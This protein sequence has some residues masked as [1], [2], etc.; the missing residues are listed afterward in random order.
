MDDLK[1]ALER[2]LLEVE[3]ELQRVDDDGHFSDDS[4]NDDNPLSAHRQG[5]LARQVQ[6]RSV[7]ASLEDNQNTDKDGAD[8]QV[9]LREELSVE[10]ERMVEERQ[11]GRRTAHRPAWQTES[12]VQPSADFGRP[13]AVRDKIV[14]R[15]VS[16][17]RIVEKDA[18]MGDRIMCANLEGHVMAPSRS[19]VPG[20]QEGGIYPP[21]A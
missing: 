15:R 7:L 12:S 9:E 6:L 21:L 1:R 13:V 19:S 18:E 16:V 14:E 10:D 5:L 8:K 11:Q 2:A 17:K 3:Q 4:D 20:D